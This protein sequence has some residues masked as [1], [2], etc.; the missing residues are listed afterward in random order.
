[1]R[2]FTHA[3][4]FVLVSAV[5]LGSAGGSFF[6]HS[7]A[8][9]AIVMA[10][11]NNPALGYFE[12]SQLVIATGERLLSFRLSTVVTPDE[13]ARPDGQRGSHRHTFGDRNA[14]HTAHW[15]LLHADPGAH[16]YIEGIRVSIQVM[17]GGLQTNDRNG[18]EPDLRSPYTYEKGFPIPPILY[19]FPGAIFAL[20][21]HRPNFTSAGGCRN[22]SRIATLDLAAIDTVKNPKVKWFYQGSG[23]VIGVH[24]SLGPFVRIIISGAL[25]SILPWA[26]YF[27][28]E[29][30]F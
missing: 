18:K 20:N 6:S 9:P 12:I 17:I 11:E 19:D 7:P 15:F 14:Y 22:C 13:E 26:A 3:V 2:K 16:D 21:H 23:I 28:Q 8:R 30:R 5:V 29:V 10:A 24:D 25:Q 1:M 4:C 27:Y